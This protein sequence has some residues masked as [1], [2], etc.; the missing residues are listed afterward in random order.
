MKKRSRAYEA[1]S[2]EADSRKLSVGAFVSSQIKPAVPPTWVRNWSSWYQIC[3]LGHQVGRMKCQFGR[4]GLK[5]GHL[6]RQV[7][8]V[9]RQVDHLGLQVDQHSAILAPF[10][11]DLG[12]LGDKMS[13]K[14]S[15]NSAPD[16]I[17]LA[18]WAILAPEGSPRTSKPA[19]EIQ[20]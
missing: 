5:I 6:G 13:P 9:G 18:S 19:L 4:L 3:L 10:W 14:T 17:Q 7:S 11:P 20:I 15:P 16:E 1:G 12:H 8:F 2:I